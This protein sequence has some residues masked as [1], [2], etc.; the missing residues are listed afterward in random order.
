[1]SKF[2]KVDTKLEVDQKL[3]LQVFLPG[4]ATLET[5]PGRLYFTIATLPVKTQEFGQ[6]DATELPR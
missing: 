4:H 6:M 3:S 2:L 5:L 1:M